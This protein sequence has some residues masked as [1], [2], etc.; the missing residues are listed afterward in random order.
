MI[1]QYA[2]CSSADLECSY[3][4]MELGTNEETNACWD[5]CSAVRWACTAQA[6]DDYSACE[7]ARSTPEP[8][9]EA[10]EYVEP[11]PEVY[12]LILDPIIEGSAE[13]ASEEPV[14]QEVT[15]EEPEIEAIEVLEVEEDI[16]PTIE[17][18]QE[19][20]AQEQ[21]DEQTDYLAASKAAA[22]VI[23]D[24]ASR[25]KDLSEFSELVDKIKDSELS[26]YDKLGLLTDT[27]KTLVEYAEMVDSG[28]STEN[29]IAKA[30]MDNFGASA[31]TLIPILK[32]IDIVATTPD[33][34]LSYMG[35]DEANPLRA[36]LTAGFIKK[37]SPT[38][39]IKETTLLMTQDDWGDIGNALVYGWN[40]VKDAEGF[41]DTAWETGK[42]AAAG[43]G[44]TT[45]AAASVIRD[46]GSGVVYVAEGVV[47]LV[48]DLLSFSI[49]D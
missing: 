15:E 44:A 20:I 30:T 42:L 34:V 22:E 7:A 23:Q 5:A 32:A 36:Y 19:T 12:E 13:V 9:E 3:G 25:Y 24:L 18:V 21:D 49:W 31:L 48:G 2:E 11:E 1:D 16:P 37:F 27:V 39:L 35:I 29:A 17:P 26:Q 40:R 8:V 4:C 33:A 28:V 6:S 10:P 46:V 45:V 41:V 43:L 14:V 38:E 47:G